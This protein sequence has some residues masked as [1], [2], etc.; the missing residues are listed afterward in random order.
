MLVRA[1]TGKLSFRF[2]NC[3]RRRAGQSRLQI[4]LADGECRSHTTDNLTA[5][6]AWRPIDGLPLVFNQSASAED[7]ACPDLT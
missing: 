5:R 4:A 3:S 6:I 7:D 1:I 2:Q